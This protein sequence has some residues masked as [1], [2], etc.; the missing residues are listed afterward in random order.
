MPLAEVEKLLLINPTKRNTM[1]VGSLL[2]SLIKS[3]THIEYVWS[4]GI[5]PSR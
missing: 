3:G 4:I 2:D 5:L 1:E